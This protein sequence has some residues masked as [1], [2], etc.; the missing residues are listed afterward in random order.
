MTKTSLRA[1]LTAAE[2]VVNRHDNGKIEQ[3]LRIIQAVPEDGIR[4][5]LRATVLKW[6]GRFPE[7]PECF[8]RKVPSAGM[9][10][11]VWVFCVLYDSDPVVRKA[12]EEHPEWF[13]RDEAGKVRR[14][15]NPWPDAG[16]YALY[17]FT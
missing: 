2:Q 16:F 15:V 11:G 4:L 13:V 6:N 5:A 9:E 8:V 12:V 10:P 14:G 7:G 1:L 3:R 17:S